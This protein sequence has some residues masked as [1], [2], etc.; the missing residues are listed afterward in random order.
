MPVW[1]AMKNTGWSRGEAALGGESRDGV[2]DSPDV[3][4]SL[5]YTLR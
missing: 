2:V 3:K 5:G 4:L 1:R